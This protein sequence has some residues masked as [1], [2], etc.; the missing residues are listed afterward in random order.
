MAHRAGRVSFTPEEDIT[1]KKMRGE[2]ITWVKIGAALGRCE[3]S[4][5]RRFILIT[6]KAPAWMKE[7]NHQAFNAKKRKKDL[8]A[9]NKWL[10]KAWNNAQSVINLCEY[11]YEKCNPYS[12]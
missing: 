6:G 2:G 11:D 5:C 9:N 8:S 7:T 10:K 4:V 12:C 1:I 3:G